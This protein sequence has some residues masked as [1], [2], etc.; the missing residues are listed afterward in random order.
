[1]PATPAK[2]RRAKARIKMQNIQSRLSAQAA[3]PADDGFREFLVA[4][5]RC[6]R[7]R[8]QLLQNELDEIGVALK[9]DLVSSEA[10]IYW[11]DEVGGLPF[12]DVGVA[13]Q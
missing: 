11:L 1:M 12:V 7:L 8:A 2:V 13:S 5:I 3:P 10:A 4:A 9:A 6:G